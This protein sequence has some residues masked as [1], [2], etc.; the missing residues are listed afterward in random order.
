M[1]GNPLAQMDAFKAFVSDIKE[2]CE[3]PP[4]ATPASVVGAYNIFS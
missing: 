1:E 4:A 2:R 3:E